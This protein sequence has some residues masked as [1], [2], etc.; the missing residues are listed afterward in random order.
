M[1]K[2]CSISRMTAMR[3]DDPQ[4]R[5]DDRAVGNGGLRHLLDVG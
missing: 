3:R 2:D 4:V 5:T 1:S